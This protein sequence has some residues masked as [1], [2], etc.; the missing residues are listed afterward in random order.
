MK[1]Y[2]NKYDFNI[3][4]EKPNNSNDSN[5][6][7]IED[8]DIQNE[9]SPLSIMNNKVQDLDKI[10]KKNNFSDFDKYKIKSDNL[11][12]SQKLF[13]RIQINKK[14]LSLFIENYYLDDFNNTRRGFYF[15]F[16][17]PFITF[18]GFLILNPFHPLRKFFFFTS[19]MGSTLFTTISFK[20]EIELLATKNTI[21][22]FKV[23]FHYNNFKIFLNL[24]RLFNHL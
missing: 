24:L 7:N 11:T 12:D 3:V 19:L 17:V 2:K 22:G 8:F 20:K 1:D 21:L 9:N 10:E 5:I 14:I 23:I 13:K 6:D 16:S 4:Y 15:C 18:F